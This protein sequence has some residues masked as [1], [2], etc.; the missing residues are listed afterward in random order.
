[1]YCKHNRIA[2]SCEDC[3][4]V[5]ALEKGHPDALRA[6]AGVKGKPDHAPVNATPEEHLDVVDVDTHVLRPDLD[7]DLGAKGTYTLIRAGDTV[8]AKLAQFPRR[9]GSYTG[10][11]S[12]KT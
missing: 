2:A 12:S 3:Q 11:S 4:F 6:A 1:M 5:A 7:R 8:P 9:P 10:P